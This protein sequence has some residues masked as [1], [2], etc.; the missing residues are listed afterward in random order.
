M[1]D[2][3]T[4]ALVPFDINA[5]PDTTEQINAL[6][7][8]IKPPPKYLPRLALTA[9]TSDLVKAQKCQAGLWVIPQGDDCHVIGASIDVLPLAVRSK[10]VDMSVKGNVIT[11]Y[12]PTSDEFQR[13]Q[14]MPK[15]AYHGQSYLVIERTT[16]R[17]LELYFGNASGRVICD[18]M[19]PFLKRGDRPASPATVS[20]KLCPGR[21]GNSFYA[22]EIV[23]CSEPLQIE[24]DMA[25][26]AKEYEKFVNPKD[27][28]VEVEAAAATGGRAR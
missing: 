24:L 4:D 7:E 16:G 23:K 9:F 12:D 20:V 21:E 27:G 8:V 10:A 3:K 26:I 15:R 5:L 28:E 14:K 17:L 13:I 6:A 18:K 25:T 1:S 11:N 19:K 2:K 22:P